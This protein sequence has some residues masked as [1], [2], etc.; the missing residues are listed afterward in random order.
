MTTYYIG[1][2]YKDYLNFR[3]EKLVCYVADYGTHAFVHC[4]REDILQDF[5]GSLHFLLPSKKLSPD[6]YI[7]NKTKDDLKQLV[8][9]IAERLH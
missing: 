8:T 3:G 2:E 4:L 9:L 6:Q 1:Q 7:R 5:S